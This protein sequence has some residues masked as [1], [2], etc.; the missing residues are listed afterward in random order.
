MPNIWRLRDMTL[1]VVLLLPLLS[2][3]H[4]PT[5]IIKKYISIL[6]AKLQSFFFPPQS[7]VHMRE[8][9]LF[10][11]YSNG[12]CDNRSCSFRLR[13]DS[14]EKGTVMEMNWMQGVLGECSQEKLNCNIISAAP[15]AHPT[16]ISGASIVLWNCSC[17]KQMVKHWTLP[18]ASH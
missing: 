10:L 14:W 4:T 15:S 13:R 3:I 16:G 2:C 17:T 7:I 9:Y 8:F 6:F 18:W 1:H 5:L 12:K 11:Q